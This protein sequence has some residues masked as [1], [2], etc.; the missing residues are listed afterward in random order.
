VGGAAHRYGTV[1]TAE[2]IAFT[3]DL[4]NKDLDALFDAWL[5]TEGR[6]AV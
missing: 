2:F 6:P 1:S 4:T 5:F 3:E